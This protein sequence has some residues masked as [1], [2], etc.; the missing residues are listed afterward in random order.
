M[1]RIIQ[2]LILLFVI[3]SINVFSQ[4]NKVKK[5]ETEITVCKVKL[6]EEGRRSNFHFN[7]IYI[8]KTDGNGEIEEVR[9]IHK[10]FP[11]YVDDGNFLSCIQSW[12]LKPKDK[13]VVVIS[14]G[15]SSDEDY[16]SISNEEEKIKIFL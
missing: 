10:D 11:D 3:Y 2:F 15:T 14:F 13:Y 9:Q 1:R 12:K 5:L 8:L 16:M 7:Y 4:S 6:T